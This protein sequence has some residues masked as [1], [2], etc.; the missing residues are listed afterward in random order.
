MIGDNLNAESLRSSWQV[1]VPTNLRAIGLLPQ[2][3]VQ[4]AIA[5]CSILVVTSKREGL[6]TLVMEAMAQ[7][8]AV[9]VP[10][11]KGCLEVIGEGEAGFI[12]QQGNIDELV[13]KTLQALADKQLG[14][15]AKKRVLREY[16]SRVIA[17]QLDKIYQRFIA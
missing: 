15:V 10:D 14:E 9:V 3:V 16:D 8:K 17:P 5:A 2:I 4:D 1:E 7:R 11:E 13:E 6:P 12:Y